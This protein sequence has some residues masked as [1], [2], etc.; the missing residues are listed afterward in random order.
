LLL[1]DLSRCAFKQTV[2]K[3]VRAPASKVR[4]VISEVGSKDD[5]S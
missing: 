1:F 5:I 4:T 2:R 3:P